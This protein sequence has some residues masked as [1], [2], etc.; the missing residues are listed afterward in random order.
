MEQVLSYIAS[1]DSYEIEELYNALAARYAVLFPN[2]EI[3]F[4]HLKRTR[5]VLCK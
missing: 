5:I 1:A 4:C 3:N 2:Y